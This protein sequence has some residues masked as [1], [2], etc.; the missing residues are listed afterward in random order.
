MIKTIIKF[1]KWLKLLNQSV[2]SL[3]R[4]WFLSKYSKAFLQQKS[5]TDSIIILG[6]GPS[7]KSTLETKKEILREHELMC[8]NHFALS[9]YYEEL[10][11]KYYVAIAH[12]LFLDDV[13]PHFIEASNKLFNA[14]ADKTTWEMK[15]F[16]TFE[17]KKHLRW[18]KILERNNK[19]EIVYLNLTPIEG[20]DSFL[21]RKFDTAKGM[22][23]P[24]NVMIP[25]IFTALHLGCKYIY[26]VGSDHNWLNELHVDENNRALFYNEHFYDKEKQAK[27]FDFSG[28]YYMKLHE[29][30]GTMSCAFESYHILQR[31]ANYKNKEIINC[32]PISYIDAFKREK[33]SEINKTK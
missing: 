28:K 27:Q 12:D 15:Y 24:H 25:A 10:K 18:Q 26:L 9:E 17:A 7:L 22:P 19:I 31:Y 23:R 2:T 13:M 33:L 5:D 14:I 1:S 30:L 29:I 21:Y 3:F 8:L 16:T 11:P 20:F 32:T 6:N 4:I